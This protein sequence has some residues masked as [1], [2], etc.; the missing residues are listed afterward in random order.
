[1][2]KLNSFYFYIFIFLFSCLYS[3]MIQHKIIENSDEN[4][5][6]VIDVL[7][8]ADYSEIENVTLYYKSPNQFNYLSKNMIHKKDN[9]FNV[10]IPGMHITNANLEYY[11]TLEL[12]NNKIYSFPYKNPKNDPIIITVNSISNKSKNIKSNIDSQDIQILS[13]L[14]NSRVFKDDLF[15]SLSYFKL[16]N[17]DK[18]LTKVFLNNRDIT[19]KITFYDNYFIYKPDFI[20][21]GQYNID[22]IFTDN[23]NRQLEPFKWSFFVISKDKLSGLSTLFNQSGRVNNSFSIN[24][25]NSERLEVNNLN[26]DYRVNFDFLKIR[27]KVKI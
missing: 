23:Y 13:P 19:S 5:D 3:Q 16:K 17:I 8:N 7:I 6:L 12:K 9:F 2:I 25:I 15:I 26:L 14:P 27:N 1:M 10:T 18:D 24:D 11:I 22:V 21:D 20:L 4:Q